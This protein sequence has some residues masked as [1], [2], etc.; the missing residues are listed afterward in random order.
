MGDSRQD[1]SAPE[2][3]VVENSE[4]TE[5]PE[6]SDHI[7]THQLNSTSPMNVERAIPLRLWRECHSYFLLGSWPNGE[8]CATPMRETPRSSKWRTALHQAREG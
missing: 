5:L 2:L 3:V 1:G 4:F 8:P 7:S 6:P